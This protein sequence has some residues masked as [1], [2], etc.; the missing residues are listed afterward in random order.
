MPHAPS[1]LPHTPRPPA[2][3]TLSLHPLLAGAPGWA[4][5]AA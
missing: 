4:G 3:G 5:G 1:R 2:S